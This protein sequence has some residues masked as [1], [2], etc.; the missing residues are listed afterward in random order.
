MAIHHKAQKTVV[1]HRKKIF[2][3][4]RIIPGEPPQTT[5]QLQ[6]MR[7]KYGS[8]INAL[9]AYRIKTW[10]L[11]K[12]EGRNSKITTMEQPN[13]DSEVKTESDEEEPNRQMEQ[14]PYR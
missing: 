6:T 9:D 1:K 12:E 13:T 4:G 3:Q 14:V 8:A 2:K 11:Q 10:Y 7:T 5:Q